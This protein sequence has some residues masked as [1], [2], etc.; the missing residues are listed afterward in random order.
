MARW[1]KNTTAAAVVAAEAQ[2]G[3]LAPCSELKDP[4]LPPL[5]L[6]RRWKLWLGFN[7]WPRNFHMPPDQP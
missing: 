5:Q 1:D 4:A 6:W 3:S 2:V 7:P